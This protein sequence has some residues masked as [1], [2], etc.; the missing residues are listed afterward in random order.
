MTNPRVYLDIE[1]D[2][3]P[4][5]R[6]GA[7]RIVLELYADK[8]PKTAEN[9]R[10]LCTGEKGNAK[11]GVP[12]HFKGSGFHRVIK[13]FMIQGGD[14]TNGDGTGGES[15]YG[16][17]FEDEDLTGKHDKPFL[18]SMAN[19]GPGTNGSQFFITTVPTPHLDGKHVVFGQVLKGKSVV[20]RIESLETGPS[21]RPSIPVTIA[22]CGEIKEGESDGIEPDT[23]GD[24]YEDFPED[25]TE[26][27]DLD[28]KPEIT[29]RIATELRALGNTAFS[30]QDYFTA[31]EKWQKAMR[32]LDVHPTI[33]PATSAQ[34]AKDY[35]TIRTALQLNSALCALKLTPSP[36]PVFALHACDAVIERLATPRAAALLSSSAS[37]TNDVA[38]AGWESEA[39]TPSPT[40]PFAQELAKAYFRRALAKVVIKDDDGADADLSSALQYAPEDAG[41]KKEKAA[42]AARREKKKAAQ[43][44]A[45]SKMFG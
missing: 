25:Y 30:K 20:R 45:Y 29:L 27:G 44:K 43:R 21:D 22:D 11:A 9:F 40:A 16:E 8:V 14:F 33:D 7:G 39:L 37:S 18:L 41:I 19:A 10:A 42:V 12:L 6:P 13:R 1:F 4:A 28:E 32:Y 23:S 15:I 34:L 3:S 26:E 24:K 38:G 17:K 35:N 31:I 2:G 36:K 5:P